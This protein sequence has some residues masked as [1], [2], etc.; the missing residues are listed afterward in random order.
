MI[1]EDA[2]KVPTCVAAVVSPANATNADYATHA[3]QYATNNAQGC[4]DA[5]QVAAGTCDVGGAS[6]N[7]IV[8]LCDKYTAAFNL[9]VSSVKTQIFTALGTTFTQ[10]NNPIG[11]T[12]PIAYA[13]DIGTDATSTMGAPGS[14][15]ANSYTLPSVAFDNNF[16]LFALSV[17][18]GILGS[19]K[20]LTDPYKFTSGQGSGAANYK[21]NT[22]GTC[23]WTT[24]YN[25]GGSRYKYTGA[26]EADVLKAASGDIYWMDEGASLGAYNRELTIGG[27]EPANPT[28]ATPMTK[29]PAIQNVYTLNSIARLKE[30]VASTDRPTSSGGPQTIT[31]AQAEEILYKFK[32]KIEDTWTDGWDTTTGDV[33]FLAFSDDT[34]V[35]GT[36][37]RIM[38]DVANDSVTLSLISYIVIIVLTAGLL[39]STD[40]EKSQVALG[41]VGVFLAIASFIAALG[42]TSLTGE[43]INI[44]QSWTLPFLMV[45]IGVDDMYIVTIA[46]RS[47]MDTSLASYVEA[48]NSIVVPV[49]MTSL[50]NL[51]IFA[52]MLLSNVPAV[53]L[54]A[55]TAIFA[56]ICLY[57]S[58]ITCFPAYVWYDAKRREGGRKDVLCCLKNG[59][60]GKKVDG[61]PLGGLF[62]NSFY[63]KV[64]TNKIF[65]LVVGIL[66]VGIIGASSA[67][68]SDYEVGLDLED[69][70][71]EGTQGHA[72]ALLRKQYFPAFPATIYYGQV[73]YKSADVQQTIIKQFESVVE[74]EHMST[75]KTETMWMAAFLKWGSRDC[76]DGPG[77]CPQVQDSG[78]NWGGGLEYDDDATP[79]GTAP[80][81]C[82]TKW[83]KN[84]KGLKLDTAATPGVCK[85]G[86]ALT[87]C[88]YS[89]DGAGTALVA[90][91]EYCP[92][93]PFTSDDNL[94]TCL[95]W[96]TN[97]SSYS[98]ASP[99][100]LTVPDTP[101]PRM[102]IKLSSA[103]GT[104]SLYSI[105]LFNT[106][107]YV[108]MITDARAVCD[109]DASLVAVAG[110]STCWVEGIGISY[111][112]QY[113][114][115]EDFAVE[116]VCTAVGAGFAVAFIFLLIDLNLGSGKASDA[117]GL[118]KSRAAL[119]G[120]LLIL[121]VM[122]MSVVST[123][124]LCCLFGVN[125]TAFA[126][127]S[128]LMSIGFA[129]EYSVHV[130]HRFITAPTTVVDAKDRVLYA[131][132]FLTLPTLLAFISSS[133]GIL[134]MAGSDMDFIKT[135]F[136]LP[137]MVVM[138]V[139][140]FFG[141]FQL[142]ALL[143]LFQGKL[144]VVGTDNSGRQRSS[145]IPAAA[146]NAL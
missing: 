128:Y 92:T 98:G 86:S 85:L 101:R 42:I 19:C 17:V 69:F 56:I 120:A 79:G 68:L 28:V 110:K 126:L 1:A 76:S 89:T 109:N 88:G 125:M 113:T 116:L 3:P 121:D 97:S 58:M 25:L 63:K 83:T 105:N 129:V 71:P 41:T 18:D 70:Y 48:M 23:T 81:D 75:I 49:T 31:D 118:H 43:K 77:I 104:P 20:G 2:C 140:Y 38:G 64:I 84:T 4:Y 59:G 112:D 99:G 39:F 7:A 11:H 124:G 60:E 44:V 135:Y 21:C 137:L 66:T 26:S 40:F 134:C 50:V 67:G 12:D 111:F 141:V 22:T 53:Y 82:I 65:G 74:T 30:R 133:V 16:K 119:I 9:T 80:T 46:A 102:P 78:G 100:Y 130:V 142:P 139:T 29:A 24:G 117:S 34:G 57:L 27:I 36:T 15:A 127:M 55:R 37:G 123:W 62:Y 122:V 52:A 108:K 61:A 72:F 138:V 90:T 132:E 106:D 8:N 51:G 54:T 6:Y 47:A 131:M 103:P 33:Q 145:L 115:I 144:L 94:A 87:S 13:A 10:A 73:D 96:W 45:G 14:F 95:E 32:E 107:K 91:D 93:M 35:V 114:D 146:N 5:S 143:C 136:F